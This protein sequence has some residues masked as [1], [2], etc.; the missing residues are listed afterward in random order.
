MRVVAM[1]L[2]GGLA[3]V[4]CGREVRTEQAP[5]AASE[6]SAALPAAGPETNGIP[7]ILYSERDADVR[8]RVEGLVRALFVELGDAVQAGQLLARLDD[9]AENAAVQAARAAADL[10]RLEHDRGLELHERQAIHRAELDRLAYSRAAAEAALRQ[11]EVRLEYTRVRAPF[12]GVITRRSVR[13][14][15]TVDAG[16]VLFRTTALQPLRVQLRVSEL[17]ARDLAPGAPITLTGA[18]GESLGARVARVAP[19][20]DPLSGTVDVLVDVIAAAGLGPGAAVSAR[21]HGAAKAAGA[22]AAATPTTR[23]A[24]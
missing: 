5:V 8:A 13:L 3:L 1:V 12:A 11:A 23:V 9:D 6:R 22:D 4:G 24:P 19:A 7:A 17:E 18:A 15:Q 21:L 2:V 10:A 20:V 16:E 14:G